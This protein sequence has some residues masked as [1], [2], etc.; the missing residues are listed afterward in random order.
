MHM[1]VIMKP[2]NIHGTWYIRLKEHTY[3]YFK[4]LG[5]VVNKGQTDLL[6]LASSVGHSFVILN[7]LL[8]N[9]IILST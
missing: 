1:H 9:I 7:F 5:H 4:S 8:F 6:T 3:A 2:A